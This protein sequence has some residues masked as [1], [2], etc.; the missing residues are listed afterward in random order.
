MPRRKPKFSGPTVE[1]FNAA[2][3][4]G[5]RVRYYSVLPADEDDFFETTTRT[6]AWDAHGTTVVMLENKSGY[7]HAGH[8]MVCNIK[9]PIPGLV[10]WWEQAN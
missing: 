1:A 10:G 7:V 4:V 9:H 2:V 8:L 3:P 6:P 5:S